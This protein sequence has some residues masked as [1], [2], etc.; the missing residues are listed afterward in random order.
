MGQ[1][2]VL[3]VGS[4]APLSAAASPVGTSAANTATTSGGVGARSGSL[5]M[6]PPLPPPT[7]PVSQTQH[8]L[9]LPTRSGVDDD[10]GSDSGEDVP[11]HA[12]LVDWLRSL[13]VVLDNPFCL[14]GKVANEFSDGLILCAAIEKL[15]LGRAVPGVC[16][17]PKMRASC[18]NNI[19][20]AFDALKEKKVRTLK[21]IA[22]A[23]TCQR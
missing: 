1:P 17:Q 6:P 23:S 13:G 10:S 20:K 22:C 11:K 7:F 3:P 12:I 15:R 16:P 19:R 18:L 14:E 5:S 9:L 4:G 21:S 8:A 2:N